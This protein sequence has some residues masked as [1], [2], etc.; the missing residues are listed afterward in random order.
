M[1]RI[2]T[3]EGLDTTLTPEA[4]VSQLKTLR[5]DRRDEV[6]DC[7]NMADEEGMEA[8]SQLVLLLD[9]TIARIADTYSVDL[10]K[11]ED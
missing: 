5:D 2:D 11:L 6:H 3:I 1:P 9:L 7:Y 10:T 4:L 8:E